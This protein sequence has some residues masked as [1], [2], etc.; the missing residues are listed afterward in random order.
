M[1]LRGCCFFMKYN[2]C[3]FCVAVFIIFF[4]LFCYKVVIIMR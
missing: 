2:S 3:S 1:K 4:A